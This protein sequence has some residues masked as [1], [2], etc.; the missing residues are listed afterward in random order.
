VKDSSPWVSPPAPERV[1]L[2]VAICTRNR[3][4]LLRRT[5]E[6]MASTLRVPAGIRWELLLVD[7]G[8]TDHTPDVTRDFA[9]RLPVRCLSQP[10]PGLSGAR[11]LAVSEASGDYIVWTDDD[12]EVD[13]AWL[14]AYAAAFR[15]WPGAAVFGGVISPLFPD[16]ALPDWLREIWPYVA[17]AYAV[18]D[19]GP[20]EA[21]LAPDR[22]PYGANMA[23]RMAEQRRHPFS[24][25]L[26]NCGA[27]RVGGEESA[28][29]RAILASGAEG[30]WV[31]G[32]R[33]LHV[34][35]RE[36]LTMEYLRAYYF[37]RGQRL[38]V[39]PENHPRMR[40]GVPGWL[41]QL[42]A[43]DAAYHAGRVLGITQ[44]HARGLRRRWIARGYLAGLPAEAPE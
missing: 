19:L 23:I 20:A 36:R 33:V 17:S 44:L 4:E 39:D 41:V 13:V 22:L 11:N 28:V 15:R 3:A 37:G 2:S 10:R 18:C 26:G 7:N 35:P 16:A 32:A 24:P 38:R 8:S 5:L 21:P 9:G 27:A 12:V 31:P 34:L 42:A 6:C 43:A 25:V 29:M 40:W 14:E 30:W 1:H